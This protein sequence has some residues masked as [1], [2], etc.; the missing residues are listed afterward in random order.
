MRPATYPHPLLSMLAAL[1]LLVLPLSGCASHRAR[2]RSNECSAP[3]CTIQP[4]VAIPVSELAERPDLSWE[5]LPELQGRPLEIAEATTVRLLSWDEILALAPRADATNRLLSNPVSSNC[6]EPAD[7]CIQQSL[8]WQAKHSAQASIARA[9]EAYLGLHECYLQ[10]QLLL[11]ARTGSEKQGRML[12]KF[13]E[14]GVDI[15][16]DS[17]ELERQ[18]LELNSQFA[19]LAKEYQTATTGLE[20][21]LNLEHQP[22][23]PLWPTT[24]QPELSLCDDLPLCLDSALKNR[25]D[26]QALLTL[27]CCVETVPLEKINF[28]ASSFSPWAGLMLPLPVKTLLGCD[29]EEEEKTIREKFRQQLCELIAENEKQIQLDV[30]LAFAR[31]WEAQEQL[32]LQT[33]VLQ[34]L[35]ASLT[36]QESLQAVE[37]LD[38]KEY[39]QLEQRI[40]AAK[41]KLVSAVINKAKAELEL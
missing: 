33:E 11:E 7:N 22:T 16:I 32:N 2:H 27:S 40:A 12:D 31:R 4:K 5:E 35:K 3:A 28:L 26:R 39:F 9:G 19:R 21:L 14:N 41:S 15:P 23:V 17:R 6:A 37:Q 8:A 25:A 18:E 13:R 38:V 10:N 29:S 30:N 20:L 34:S 1:A 24:M 36:D